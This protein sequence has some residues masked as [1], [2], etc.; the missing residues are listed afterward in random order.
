[1]IDIGE[2]TLKDTKVT[3]KDL[4]K[5]KKQLEMTGDIFAR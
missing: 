2:V 5:G 4:N 1:M 3:K